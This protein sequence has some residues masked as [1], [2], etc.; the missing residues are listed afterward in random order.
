[1]V[2]EDEVGEMNRTGKMIR[3]PDISML[4]LKMVDDSGQTPRQTAVKETALKMVR[5]ADM[6]E[7]Q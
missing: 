2:S 1:M 7:Q 6:Y 4:S 5:L 3:L